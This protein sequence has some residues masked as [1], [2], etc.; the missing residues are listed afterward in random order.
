[1]LFSFYQAEQRCR[2]QLRPFVKQVGGIRGKNHVDFAD[3]RVNKVLPKRV[4]LSITYHA[5]RPDKYVRYVA[6]IPCQKFSALN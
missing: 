3:E 1:M 5:K 6:H 4:N 2:G